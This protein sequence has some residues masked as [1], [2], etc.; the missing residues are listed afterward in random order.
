MEDRAAYHTQAPEGPRNLTVPL[1]TW[2]RTKGFTATERVQSQFA[3]VEAHWLGPM[4]DRYEF[5]YT[6]TAGPEPDATCQLTVYWQG[7]PEKLF[8]AQRVRRLREARL[9]LTNCVRYANAR[10]L[11]R[12]AALPTAS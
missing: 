7:L 9:L 5:T 4:N 11:A 2:L 8:T 6:W 1:A 10:L 12:L 3:T